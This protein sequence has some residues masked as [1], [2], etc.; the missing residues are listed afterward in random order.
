MRELDIEEAIEQLRGIKE[1]CMGL[2][3]S[4]LAQEE[5]HVY[6]L[7][8]ENLCSIIPALEKGFDELHNQLDGTSAE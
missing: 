4:D 6:N 8:A 3:S 7:I 1:M 2:S 5:R